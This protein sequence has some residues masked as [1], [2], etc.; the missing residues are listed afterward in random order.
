MAWEARSPMA[1]HLLAQIGGRVF[2]RERELSAVFNDQ[3][4]LAQTVVQFGG[5]AG[6]LGFLRG[7]E[8]KKYI[9]HARA[10]RVARRWRDPVRPDVWR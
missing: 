1:F 10:A 5:D 3:K 6:A 8:L 7:D 9:P 2:P 4:I